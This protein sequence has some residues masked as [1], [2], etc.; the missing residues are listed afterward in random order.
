MVDIAAA[1]KFASTSLKGAQVAE[2]FG[3]ASFSVGGKVF[4][5]T[6]PEGLV[7]KLP[8]PDITRVLADREAEPLVMGKRVMR[9]WILLRLSAPDEYR[10]ELPL[11]RAAMKF[12]TAR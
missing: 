3:N 4:A 9:E 12:V 10:K 11:L 1:R 2:K 7:L 5:F 8:A 6:R